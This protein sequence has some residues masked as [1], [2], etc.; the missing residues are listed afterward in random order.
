MISPSVSFHVCKVSFR[1]H[2]AHTMYKF[3][4]QCGAFRVDSSE[5]VHMFCST[6][7]HFSVKTVRQSQN[8]MLYKRTTVL[9]QSQNNKMLYKRTTVL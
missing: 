5:L 9:G 2:D 8:K 3:I 4:T 1:E 6:Y 7:I